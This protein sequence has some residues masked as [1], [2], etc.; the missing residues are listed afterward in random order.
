[1]STT[2]LAETE[3]RIDGDP[4]GIDAG[5]AASGIRA[6]E[7]A[8]T[9]RHHI[10]VARRLLHGARLALHVH[11]ADAGTACS[12]PRRAP[13]ARRGPHVVDDVRAGIDTRRA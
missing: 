7:I 12:P 1:M 5:L 6:R 4:R 9:S 11:E 3:T 13:R 8:L 10:L 2:R